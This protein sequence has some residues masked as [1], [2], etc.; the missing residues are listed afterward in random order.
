[1]LTVLP[2]L[3]KNVNARD[4]DELEL[5]E[6]EE[7]E[8]VRVPLTDNVLVLVVAAVVAVACVVVVLITEALADAVAAPA[9]VGTMTIVATPTLFVNAVPDVGLSDAELP[10]TNVTT[11]L[12][13]ATPVACVI[14]AVKV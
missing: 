7:T 9:V 10:A 2:P 11:T 5:L 3:S 13:T 4:E 14:V 6:L 8:Y 12:D 1:V